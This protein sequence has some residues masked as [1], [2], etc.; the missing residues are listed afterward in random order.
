[1]AYCVHWVLRQIHIWA[2]LIFQVYG[3]GACPS[4]AH[5]S[6]G[7]LPRCLHRK[8]VAWNNVVGMLVQELGGAKYMVLS[9]RDDVADHAQWAQAL[10]AQRIIH[11]LE[12]NRSQG[13]QYAPAP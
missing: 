8:L 3:S 5:S 1:M 10:G 7:I 9:H 2:S 6:R 13:T 12:A 4:A 11:R